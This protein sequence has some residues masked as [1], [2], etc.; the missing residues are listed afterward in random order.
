MQTRPSYKNRPAAAFVRLDGDTGASY[1]AVGPKWELVEFRRWSATEK[2]PP[3]VQGGSTATPAVGP[4][5][6][7]LQLTGGASTASDIA[8]GRP[9][10]TPR[11]VHSAVGAPMLMPL[12]DR[13]TNRFLWERT[14]SGEGS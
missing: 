1:F 8:H 4:A 2:R 10:S 12:Y 14:R 9:E 3:P 11:S 6:P 13:A 7:P 5:P